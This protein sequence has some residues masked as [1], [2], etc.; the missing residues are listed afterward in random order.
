MEARNGQILSNSSSHILYIISGEI[1]MFYIN[2][3]EE[4]PNPAHLLKTFPTGHFAFLH[5]LDGDDIFETD[6]L[7]KM[8]L[9]CTSSD[10][11]PT[12][13]LCISKEKMMEYASSLQL[14][15]LKTILQTRYSLLY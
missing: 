7:L 14:Q 11:Q 12:K 1:S 3:D 9:Q 5:D 6:R 8:I 10:E 15:T 2:R 13:F 4:T